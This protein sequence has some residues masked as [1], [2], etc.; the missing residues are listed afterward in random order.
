[1]WGIHDKSC[2]LPGVVQSTKTPQAW[3]YE[4]KS[5]SPISGLAPKIR[6]NTKK[7]QNWPENDQFGNFSVFSFFVFLGAKPEM[8]DFVIFSDFFRISRL[9]G[10]LYSVPPQGDRKTRSNLLNF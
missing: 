1:M 9:E 4:K 2:D 7:F 5:K 3:K 6:K 8:G 10:F